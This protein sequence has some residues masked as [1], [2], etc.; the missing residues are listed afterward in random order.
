MRTIVKST[1]KHISNSSV[2]VIII[3]CRIFN[4]VAKIAK[5]IY[6]QLRIVMQIKFRKCTSE[7]LITTYQWLINYAHR[8]IDVD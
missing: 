2:N 5:T 1:N 4:N 7:Y 8:F 3:R 6:K